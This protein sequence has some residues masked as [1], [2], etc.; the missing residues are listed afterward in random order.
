MPTPRR[1][2]AAPWLATA[3]PASQALLEAGSATRVA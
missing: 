1:R 2:P 3:A